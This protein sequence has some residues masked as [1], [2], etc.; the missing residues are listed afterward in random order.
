[1]EIE[2]E[3]EE[4]FFNDYCPKCGD[5]FEVKIPEFESDLEDDGDEEE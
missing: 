2:G 4:D 1:L 3:Y 5:E